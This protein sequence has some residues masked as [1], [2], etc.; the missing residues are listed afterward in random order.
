MNLSPTNG[1]VWCWRGE[2]S[3]AQPALE[4]RAQVE[5]KVESI[6]GLRE[7]T[8]RVPGEVEGLVGSSEGGFEVP[9]EGIDRAELRQFD[10]PSAPIGHHALVI[11]ADPLHRPEAPQAVA[12]HAGR[13]RQAARRELRY[14]LA[15]ERLLAQAHEQGMALERGLHRRR[16]RH[17]VLG[18]A[19]HLASGA[20]SAETGIVDLHATVEECTP[21]CSVSCFSL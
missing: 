5:P 18:T 8:M 4:D 14:G 19:P 15:G 17:L 3:R 10:A 9:E 21:E 2:N 1:L 6:W 12:D 11:G 13:R 7:V 20:L 16:E